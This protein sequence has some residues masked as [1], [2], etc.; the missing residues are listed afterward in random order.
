MNAIVSKSI[1]MGDLPM[2]VSRF[3]VAMFGSSIPS[4]T[5]L[6]QTLNDEDIIS[7]V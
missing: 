4:T 7:T 2:P 5:T 6:R 3:H 1:S